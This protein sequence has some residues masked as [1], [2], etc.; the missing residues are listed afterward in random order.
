MKYK[1]FVRDGEQVTTVIE[2][3]IGGRKKVKVTRVRMGTIDR[4]SLLAEIKKS[5]PEMQKTI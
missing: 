5:V 4:A 3:V 1:I 2:R